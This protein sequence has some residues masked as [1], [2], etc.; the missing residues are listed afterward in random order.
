MLVY[1]KYVSR[2][3]MV[4]AWADL[5]NLTRTGKLQVVL[6]NQL[7]GIVSHPTH[8]MSRALGFSLLPNYPGL[9]R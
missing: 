4:K 2:K 7:L 6:A 8:L 5:D 9:P 1:V 3:T